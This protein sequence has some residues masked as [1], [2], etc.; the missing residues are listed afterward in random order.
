[1]LVWME[2]VAQ[3]KTEFRKAVAVAPTSPLG[4]EAKRFLDR[5]ENVGTK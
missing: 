4:M 2:Q 5:L 3:A 1:M